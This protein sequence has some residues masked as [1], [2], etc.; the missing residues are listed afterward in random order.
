MHSKEECQLFVGCIFCD[1]HQV[2]QHYFGVMGLVSLYHTFWV[3]LDMGC[4]V[5]WK[6]LCVCIF[7][8]PL[9]YILAC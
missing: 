9:G 8:I 6:V 2:W 3:V 4:V 5:V 7:A 1:H